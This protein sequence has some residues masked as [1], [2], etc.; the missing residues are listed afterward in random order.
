II[1]QALAHLP[2]LDEQMRPVHPM[3]HERLAGRL[4]SRAFAL[5]NFI[6]VMREDQ[7]LA[8]EVQVEAGAEQFHAHG[9]AFDVPAWT[10]FA[11]G[12][13]PK[14]V[15]ILRHACFPEREVRD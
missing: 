10:A 11:P 14:D 4:E 5:R 3:L 12:T 15:T 13:R 8:A 1:T 2:S 7:V 6:L 9:A